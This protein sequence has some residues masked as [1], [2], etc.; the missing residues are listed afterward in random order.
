MTQCDCTAI[1]KLAGNFCYWCQLAV[2]NE[3]TPSPEILQKEMSVI[4][5]NIVQQ[6]ADDN[7]KALERGWEETLNKKHHYGK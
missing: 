1:D 5:K 6:I 7:R 2:V 4:A 3:L